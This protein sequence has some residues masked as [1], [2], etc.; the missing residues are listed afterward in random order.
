MSKLLL[1]AALVL[2]DCGSGWS[3]FAAD[4]GEM[5]SYACSY[6]SPKLGTAG[7][8]RIG[9]KE[10]QI[11]K[12][13][14]GN[15]TSGWPGKPGYACSFTADR[16]DGAQ[17][18]SDVGGATTVEFEDAAA[19]GGNSIKVTRDPGGFTIDMGNAKSS[20]ACGAGGE[21]PMSVYVPFSGRKCG[22]KFQPQ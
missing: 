8:V 17:R 20:S 11:R 15:S 7:N 5:R 1:I 3:A 6:K 2:L 13:D 12:I 10:G 21:L 14:F 16:G 4:N 22:V 18:W 19:Y 9:A